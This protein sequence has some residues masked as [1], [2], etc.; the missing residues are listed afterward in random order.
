MST[1]LNDSKLL[2]L[3]IQQPDQLMSIYSYLEHSNNAYRQKILDFTIT[4]LEGVLYADDTE[5]LNVLTDQ[6]NQNM[7]EGFF[8]P[9]GTYLVSHEKSQGLSPVNDSKFTLYKRN[10]KLQKQEEQYVMNLKRLAGGRK[11]NFRM[12]VKKVSSQDVETEKELSKIIKNYK[13]Q[14]KEAKIAAQKQAENTDKLY[15]VF[16]VKKLGVYNVDRIYKRQN[17]ITV[18]AD[19]QWDKAQNKIPITVYL[20]SGKN[21]SVVIPFHPKDWDKFS[22][23][24]KDQNQLIAILPD[25]KIAYFKPKD[26]AKINLN[27]VNKQDKFTFKLHTKATTGS[28]D[29]L[30]AILN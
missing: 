1:I 10:P 27:K 8:S 20:V 7:F 13:K 11:S 25:S 23:N 3:Y 24:P 21:Q 4:N 15:R 5:L 26:F 12:V 6:R 2:D 19:F 22:F 17:I 16:E 30:K 29:E 18:N 9:K 28:L 14:I